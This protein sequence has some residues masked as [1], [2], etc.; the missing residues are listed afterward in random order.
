M[1]SDE[2]LFA[3]LDG[4]LEAEDAARVAAQV[5]ADAELAERAERHRALRARLKSA[6]DP[7][8]DAP[9]PP[10]LLAAANAAP[11]EVIDLA[12]ARQDRSARRGWTPLA[13]WAAIAAT[14]AIGFFGG[15]MVPSG[16]P[17]PV[18]V[19][20]GRIYAAASLGEAL[21]TQLASAPSGA[22]RIGLTFR[23]QSGAICRSFT[24]AAGSGLACRDDDRWQLR[25][26]F[27]APEGQHG[28][29]RM[30]AGMD[31]NLAAL[32]D[33]SMAGEPFDAAAERAAKDKGW[34]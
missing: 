2:T 19:E 1:V 26:L 12:A 7:I 8:A 11:A 25:G 22:V 13:Q 34:R 20:G 28:H 18:T 9:L 17:G 24:A 27:T 5:A 3:W 6:F 14:L 21:D 30:A 16:E 10:R 31:A 15:T 33:S 23:D 4:E 29:Y 32:I